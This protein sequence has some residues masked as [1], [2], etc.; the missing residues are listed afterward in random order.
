MSV[1]WP[2]RPRYGAEMPYGTV[3]ETDVIFSDTQH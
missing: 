3:Q 1:H 2:N